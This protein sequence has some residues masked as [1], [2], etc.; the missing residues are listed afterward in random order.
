[1]RQ[2]RTLWLNQADAGDRDARLVAGLRILD[3]QAWAELYDAHHA[4]LWRYVYGR[5]GGRDIADEVAAQ[6]FAEALASI[7]SFEYRGKPVLAWLYR[8]AR[9]QTAKYL[10][11]RRHE[12]PL[13]PDLP[14]QPLDDR[15]NSVAL[16]QAMRKL[17][18]HQREIIALRFYAGYSTR[19]IAAALSKSE[20]A[21]YSQE[22]RALA[23]MRRFFA[24]ES[25]DRWRR[26][27]K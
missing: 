4:Q 27:A 12:Q 16:A 3:E 1:V 20:A 19:E 9:N 15:L 21:V 13:A 24:P 8:I 17:T 10:R 26:P 18:K 7:A 11:A 5:T 25:K 23:S 2:V 6:V 14:V 22:A